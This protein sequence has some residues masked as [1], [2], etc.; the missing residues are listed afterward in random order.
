MRLVCIKDK[1]EVR[2]PGNDGTL[3]G[4]DLTIG[5]SYKGQILC[6]K[7]PSPGDFTQ[8]GYHYQAVFLCFNDAKTWKTYNLRDYF[9]V[10]DQENQKE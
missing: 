7:L 8:N 3:F 10:S 4:V 1:T 6:G 2:G 5:K 9:C